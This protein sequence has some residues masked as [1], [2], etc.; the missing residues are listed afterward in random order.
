MM[1]RQF[2]TQGSTREWA[3][4]LSMLTTAGVT[5]ALPLGSSDRVHITEHILRNLHHLS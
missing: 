4:H 2:W 3:L 1:T 5:L